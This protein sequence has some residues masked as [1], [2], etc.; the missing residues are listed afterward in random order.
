[1]TIINSGRLWS[2]IALEIILLLS[3]FAIF[4][5]IFT[6]GKIRKDYLSSKG[7]SKSSLWFAIL[8]QILAMVLIY[9]S[10]I[11]GSIISF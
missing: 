5:F 3:I 6:S 2:G 7:L 4:Y 1:M 9:F 11:D 10:N 8:L